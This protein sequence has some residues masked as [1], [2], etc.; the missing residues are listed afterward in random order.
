M[1]YIV[2]LFIVFSG[3]GMGGISAQNI[4]YG[5]ELDTA[6]MLIGDQQHLTFKLES[7]GA[8]KINF[9]QLKDTIVR[10]VEIISGPVRDSLKG[11]NGKW[12]YTERYMITAFDTGVYVIPSF[13]IVVEDENYNNVVRTEP[14]AFVVNT[15]KVDEQQGYYDIVAPYGAPWNFVEIL[16]YLWWIIGGGIVVA[17]VV[18]YLIRRKKNKP[19]FTREVVRI[20]PYEKAL[21]E[22]EHLKT[23]KLWQSGKVKAYYTSLTDTVRQY[24]VGELQIPAMEQTS[25]ETL[26]ALQGRKEVS[27]EDREQLAKMLET[28]DFVKFAKSTPL[29][30]ENI[31]NM[32]IAYRFLNNTHNRILEK[33]A[34]EEKDKKEPE[35]QV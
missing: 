11:K 5:M 17:L 18:W 27:T 28:S 19:L 35:T 9:P 3:W 24:I 30:E 21:K 26:Q 22:L 2:L 20:P 32:D 16:P 25:V 1:K 31:Q 12:L 14:L 13:P 10:G 33:Q 6:Y 15:Y 23:E 29:P 34:E 8:L 7:D 4:E